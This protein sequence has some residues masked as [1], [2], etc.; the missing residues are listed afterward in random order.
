MTF[1]S[2]SPLIPHYHSSKAKA[3]QKNGENNVFSGN[4]ILVPKL[5][6]NMFSL[7]DKALKQEN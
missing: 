1:P 2:L 6:E 4:T 3:A 7:G 5:S